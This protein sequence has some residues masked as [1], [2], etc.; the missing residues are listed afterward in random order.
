MAKSKS[1]VRKYEPSLF[2][3]D[4]SSGFRSPERKRILGQKEMVDLLHSYGA[5]SNSR[6]GDDDSLRFVDYLSMGDNQSPFGNLG[7][8][9]ESAGTMNESWHH[10]ANDKDY[11]S[12]KQLLRRLVTIVGNGGNYLL[13]V[14]P[15]ER[16]VIPEPDVTRLKAIGAWLRTNGEA[17]YGT[18][19]SPHP[20][21]FSWGSITQRKVDGQSLLYLNVVDWPE[22]GKFELYGLDN[23]ILKASLLDG[24]K[25]L[26]H[27][28]SFDPAAALTKHTITI[29]KEA[30]DPNVS[31][32]VL[33]INGS[34]SMEQNHLQQ[35][36]GSVRLWGYQAKIHDSKFIPGK[37]KRAIDYKMFTV[38]LRVEGIRPERMLSLSGLQNEGDAIS[39]DLKMVTPGEYEVEVVTLGTNPSTKL[40]AYIAGQVVEN[41]LKEH[42]NK[43]TIELASHLHESYATLGQI[44]IPSSGLYTLALEVVSD[45]EGKGPRIRSVRLV[46]AKT[47]P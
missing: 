44:Q 37:L 36:D 47:S 34:P 32:I 8:P 46:P 28:S 4:G 17:I 29:P 30:P 23:Q 6:L 41:T 1:S 7:V 24:G 31:V 14:G 39:W 5:I 9:F 40:K 3:F 22:D 45:L 11:K 18:S 19:A 20:H 38:P 10:R 15:D 42:S 16:G 25:E 12:V 26:E 27:S 2:W 21:G 33:E 13:N 35:Q 43:K